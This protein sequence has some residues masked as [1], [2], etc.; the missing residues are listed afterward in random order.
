MVGGN[1]CL[2]ALR[3][4]TRA[5][6]ALL[7]SD[8][9]AAGAERGGQHSAAAQPVGG[10]LALPGWGGWR[11]ATL[12]LPDSA[13]A[14]V[15]LALLVEVRLRG[16]VCGACL[17]PAGLSQWCTMLASRKVFLQPALQGQIQTPA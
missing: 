7:G 11:G 14:P 12:V 10:R 16:T 4:V 3:P 8:C 1:A 9:R 2:P 13:T 17:R 5:G 6:L 15:G